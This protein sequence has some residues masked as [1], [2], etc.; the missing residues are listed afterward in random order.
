MLELN[1][2]RFDTA[3]W[4]AYT[5]GSYALSSLEVS[6]LRSNV[7]LGVG[8][9]NTWS[10]SEMFLGFSILGCSEEESI[11]SYKNNPINKSKFKTLQ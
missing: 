10:W 6:S 2:C 7:R 11:G 9:W 5:K 3:A 1:S 8:S 4:T